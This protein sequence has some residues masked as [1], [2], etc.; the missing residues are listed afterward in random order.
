MVK[1]WRFTQYD[2][3]TKVESLSV[4]IHRLSEKQ[5][6]S[7]LSHLAARHLSFSEVVQ[8]SLSK[9][10]GPPVRSIQLEV[11]RDGTYQRYESGEN[12]HYT[13]DIVDE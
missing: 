4:P 12:P 9:H 1:K 3:T 2:G 7:V 13:L 6:Q 5:A 11:R 8:S 10:K